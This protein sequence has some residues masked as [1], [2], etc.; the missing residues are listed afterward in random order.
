MIKPGMKKGEKF[1]DGGIEYVVESVLPDGNYISK[2]AD[3]VVEEQE[4]VPEEVEESTEEAAEEV[5]EEST[6][7]AEEPKIEEAP[8]VEVKA[9]VKNTRNGKRR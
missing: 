1:I 6:T 3:H 8:K 7:V 4:E 9:P 5:S 2:R